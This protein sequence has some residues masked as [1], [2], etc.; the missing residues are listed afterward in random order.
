MLK[1][2][3]ERLLEARKATP[4]EERSAPHLRSAGPDRMFEASL[5]AARKMFPLVSRP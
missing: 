3:L 1:G 2:P 5:D 4:E